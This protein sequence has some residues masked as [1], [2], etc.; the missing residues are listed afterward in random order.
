MKCNGR[1]QLARLESEYYVRARVPIPLRSERKFLDFAS[2]VVPVSE[3]PRIDVVRDLLSWFGS[4][5]DDYPRASERFSSVGVVST[6][7]SVFLV[8]QTQVQE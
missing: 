5:A 3:F 8:R 2:E 4:D 1:I 6:P 7:P